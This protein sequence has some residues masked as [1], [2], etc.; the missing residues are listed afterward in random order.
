MNPGG[1]IIGGV[2]LYLFYVSYYGKRKHINRNIWQ[3][4]IFIPLGMLFIVISFLS[5]IIA[6]IGFYLG[7]ATL[8]WLSLSVIIYHY[9]NNML[10]MKY[11][12]TTRKIF[13][14]LIFII[15]SIFILWFIFKAFIL[16]FGGIYLK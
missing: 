10:W 14:V 3:I 11:S 7:I 13:F 6:N 5:P 15:K 1:I 9:K 12:K 8:I 4:Y 16:W 2:C